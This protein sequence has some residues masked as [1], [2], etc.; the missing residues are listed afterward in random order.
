LKL[1]CHLGKTFKSEL[2]DMVWSNELIL[3]LA[4]TLCFILFKEI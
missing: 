2:L 1:R 4:T 3:F